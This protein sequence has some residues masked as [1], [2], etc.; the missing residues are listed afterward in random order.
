MI[1]REPIMRTRNC[2]STATALSCKQLEKA[3][4][5]RTWIGG[6]GE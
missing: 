1:G 3:C 5:P 2:T 4:W 6:L